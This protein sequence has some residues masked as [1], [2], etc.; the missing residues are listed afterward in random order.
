MRSTFSPVNRS[1]FRLAAPPLAAHHPYLL[2]SKPL[3]RGKG[4]EKWSRG[5]RSTNRRLETRQTIAISCCKKQVIVSSKGGQL[6]KFAHL[7]R[8]GFKRA[9]R[10][11]HQPRKAS[12]QVHTQTNSTLYPYL[13]LGKGGG[14]SNS[15]ESILGLQTSFS[16]VPYLTP[17]LRKAPERE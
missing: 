2:S 16:K 5:L 17:Y 8:R 1:Y 13:T 7:V 9:A 14:S 10:R 15:I 3:G 11:N 12:T 6:S 4:G